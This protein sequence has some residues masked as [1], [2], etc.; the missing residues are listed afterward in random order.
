MVFEDVSDAMM[1]NIYI[2]LMIS[3]ARTMQEIPGSML[4]CFPRNDWRDRAIK[5]QGA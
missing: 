2:L 1:R 5:Y 3:M 4:D